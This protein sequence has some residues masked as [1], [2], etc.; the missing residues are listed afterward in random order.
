MIKKPK[1][2]LIGGLPRPS[3]GVTVFLGR[4]V[5]RLGEKISFHVLDIH[6]GQK[7]PSRA[8]THRIVPR[9]KLLK[10]PWLI[11]HIVF[12]RGDIIHFNY[13]GCHALIALAMLPKLNRRFY[14]TLH[15]G[16]QVEKLESFGWIRATL[17]RLGIKKVD[18][19]FSLCS[20]HDELYRRLRFQSEIVKTKTQIPPPD[21]SPAPVDVQHSN[22]RASCRHVLVSSGH[23]NRTYNFEFLVRFVTERPTVGG[24]LFLYG[25]QGDLEYLRELQNASDPSRFVFYFNKDETTFLSALKYSEAYVRPTHV[26]S[27]GIAVADSLSLGIPA[28]ASNVCERSQGAVICNSLDYLDF[29]EKLDL[30]L[31]ATPP[32][33]TDEKNFVN[34]YLTSYLAVVK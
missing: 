27:W 22:L 5:N 29:A 10:S 7:E 24:I 21:I 8:V 33:L 16:S 31:S 4:L 23:V 20:N 6:Q 3:G 26:D 15:N 13:S 34:D 11:W 19:A 14:L 9:S 12:F 28:I 2:L 17:V 25:D 32:Q 30:M 18:V 1:V